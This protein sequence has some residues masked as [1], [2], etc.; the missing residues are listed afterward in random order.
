MSSS[1]AIFYIAFY[2]AFGVCAISVWHNALP[3]KLEWERE[4][5]SNQRGQK[6]DF[7]RIL[8]ARFLTQ[9]KSQKFFQR[10][11]LQ[12]VQSSQFATNRMQ[13]SHMRSGDFKGLARFA[14]GPQHYFNVITTRR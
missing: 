12:N 13:N 11:S 2:H 1:I 4:I 9:R 5:L 14:Q 3:I 8:E 7:P 6:I 10:K